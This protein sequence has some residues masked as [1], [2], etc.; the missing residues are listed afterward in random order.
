[1]ELAA[2]ELYLGTGAAPGPGVP[3][4]ESYDYLEAATRWANAYM[5]AADAGQDSLNLYDVAGF[6]HYDLYRAM[7]DSG[8]AHNLYVN[9]G[10]VLNDMRDQLRLGSKLGARDAFGL[11]NS[12]GDVDPVP[13]AL[14]YAAE[15]RLYDELLGRPVFEGLAS[16]ELGWLLGANAWGSSF[17]VG[18]GSQFPRCL[19]HQVANLEG[20]LDG[21][22]A[23]LAGAIV[24]GPTDASNLRGLGAPDGYRPCPARGNP[25]RT[26]DSGRFR[27][28]DS[29]RSPATSEPAD[30]YGALGLFAFAQAAA[31]PVKAPF[32]DV[33]R[34]RAKPAR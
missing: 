1:M 16:T 21:Q 13:H 34:V 5:T 33:A 8:N 18:A 22:G 26:F 4:P 14:G 7:V 27:Y 19:A 9:A 28:L 15:A 24:D 6:A 31:A 23:L 3:H 17:V 10:G 11:A 12:S 30:D 2:T 25:F 32:L 29:V 20:S